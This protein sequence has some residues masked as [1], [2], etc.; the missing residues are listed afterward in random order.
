M[1]FMNLDNEKSDTRCP[2]DQLDEVLATFRDAVLSGASHYIT[3]EF[4]RET[5]GR[6]VTVVKDDAL[7]AMID[8]GA[9]PTV[10]PPPASAGPAAHCAACARSGVGACDDFPDCP[11]GGTGNKAAAFRTQPRSAP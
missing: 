1:L 4:M 7:P 8:M 10:G 2:D 9:E 5:T 11:G 3:L 6:A